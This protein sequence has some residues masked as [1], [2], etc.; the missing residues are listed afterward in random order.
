MRRK[1]HPLTEHMLAQVKAATTPPEPTGERSSHACNTDRH[2]TGAWEYRVLR[3]QYGRWC[4][5]GYFAALDRA[6]DVH[7]ESDPTFRLQRCEW[8]AAPEVS[9]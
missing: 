6:L 1:V 8:T 7:N 3:Y 2:T 9:G 4:A 5:I